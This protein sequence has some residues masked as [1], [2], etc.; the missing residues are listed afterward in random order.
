MNLRG[1]WCVIPAYNNAATAPGIAARARRI[2]PN[3]LVVDDGSTDA[4][5]AEC[6]AGLDVTVL[7]HS[8][9]LGKGAAIL[10][11]LNHLRQ[12]PEVRYMITIDADGQ[13]DPEDIPR[14]YPFLERND[15]SLV[16][17]CRDFSG[18]NIPDSSRFGRRFANFWMRIETGIKVGDCQSGFRA[19]PVRYIGQLHFLTRR[20]TFETEVLTRAAWANLELHDVPVHVHYPKKEERISHFHPWKDNFRL[21]CLHIHLIGIRMLPVP[22]KKLRPSPR[23]PYSIF[24]PRELFR[25]LLNE[26]ASPEGL[27]ASAGIASFLAV[28]PL[29]GCHI[30]AILY[31]AERLHL[32]KIMALAIQNLYMPPLSPFLCIELGFRMR[33]GHWLTELTLQTCVKELHFRLF[34][35]FLGSLVLAPFWGFAAG[36][37]V[38]FITSFLQ[39]RRNGADGKS[40]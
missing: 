9:N 19:Y 5:L 10:T 14:F 28:L 33:N 7:R 11:A 6:C 24:R 18:P 2:L 38:Y 8:R 26:N 25:A 39:R 30:L 36:T 13:H 35:W 22:K 16:I 27:A 1:I 17:G 3:V 20:Y 34:E 21:T 15:F 4:N 12:D 29:P 23:F 40:Q 31:T 32:N 37:A